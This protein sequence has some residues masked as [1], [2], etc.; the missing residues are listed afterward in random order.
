MIFGSD[1]DPD[2]KD[3][4]LRPSFS[5]GNRIRRLVWQV[6]AFF[7]F[8]YTPAPFHGW[9][10]IVL[11]VFGAS[12]GKSNFIY[13][14]AK[15]WAPWLLKTG[16]VVTLGPLCEVYNPG[17]VFI[18]HHCIVSQGAYLCGATH[19]PDDPAFPFIAKKI[20]LGA[21]SWVCARAVVLPGV[22]MGEGAVLGAAAVASR[23]L[24]PWTIHAGN[25][26]RLIRARRRQVQNP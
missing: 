18:D 20:E 24:A 5:S 25:P 1:H 8:R 2:S 7:V 3:A 10:C 12:I 23:S 15:I 26:A 16:D 21:Y 22:T 9:R 19:D 13:P 17:G 6:V 11:R 4:L 14:S